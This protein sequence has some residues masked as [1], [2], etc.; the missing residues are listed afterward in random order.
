MSSRFKSIKLRVVDVITDRVVPAPTGCEYVVL[1]YVWGGAVPFTLESVDIAYEPTQT[2]TFENSYST[3]Q[4]QNLPQT[5]QDAMFVTSAIGERY[6]WA[7]C[8]CI[9]QDDLEELQRNINCMDYIFSAA[10]LTI[11]A[12]T[13]DNANAGLPGIHPE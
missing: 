6:L 3:L 7:D 1:S 12:A 5:I 2:R 9:V 4:R 13:G 8:L 10:K 11:I